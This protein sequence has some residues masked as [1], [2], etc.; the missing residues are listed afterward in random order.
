MTPQKH[1]EEGPAIEGWEQADKFL[2]EVLTLEAQ[3]QKIDGEKDEIV[4][5]VKD[6]YVNGDGDDALLRIRLALKLDGKGVDV[7]AAGSK[8]KAT[9]AA[10]LAKGLQAFAE[11]RK[12]ELGDKKSKALN[13][14]VLGF[15]LGTGTLETIKKMT[16]AKVL[17][18]LQAA[19]S[20]KKR[21]VRVKEE[22]D[23]DALI[24][25]IR[26]KALKAEEAQKI[27]V[28]LDKSDVF[29]YEVKKDATVAPDAV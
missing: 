22:V 5:L 6:L 3:V 20:W 19:K 18:T 21:F 29:F 10:L 8:E 14:G 1:V 9:R 17:L 28:Y 23:K 15:R 13:N 4:K 2:G 12:K 24:A 11:A 25:A 27:G 7:T 16:W 26:N